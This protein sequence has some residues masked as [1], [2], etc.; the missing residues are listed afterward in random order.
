VIALLSAFSQ[1]QSEQ[2][3]GP[4]SINLTPL[5]RTR[6]NGYADYSLCA[7]CLDNDFRPIEMT[8]QDEDRRLVWSWSSDSEYPMIPSE[9]RVVKWRQN[10]HISARSVVNMNA[11]S[12]VDSSSV[13]VT[14]APVDMGRLDKSPPLNSRETEWRKASG[15]SEFRAFDWSYAFNLG[16]LKKW[17][18]EA[19]LMVA[20]GRSEFEPLDIQVKAERHRETSIILYWAAISI[21]ALILFLSARRFTK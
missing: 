14:K 1:T 13:G 11:L 21:A 18:L 10:S 6:M 4:L 8:S 7:E 2:S 17:I 19:E 12:F 3:L 5:N 15:S 9:L 16:L 20:G